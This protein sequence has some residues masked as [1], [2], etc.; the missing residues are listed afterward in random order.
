MKPNEIRSKVLFGVKPKHQPDADI[1]LR[2]RRS[3]GRG[4]YG[5]ARLAK[6]VGGVVVGRSKAVRLPSGKWQSIDIQHPPDVV[7]ELFS[8]ESKWLVRVPTNISKVMIQAVRNAP[9]GLVPVGVI[10][11]RGNR[12]VFYILMESD[13]LDLHI[14]DKVISQEK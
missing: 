9:E 7:T 11:D 6:R 12:T 2:N 5:E 4:H 13:F 1:A 14:G 3:R 8:F 10:G